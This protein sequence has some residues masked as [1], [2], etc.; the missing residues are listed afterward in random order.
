MGGDYGTSAIIGFLF[1][2]VATFFTIKFLI[3]QIRDVCS[4]DYASVYRKPNSFNLTRKSDRFMYRD[5]DV[6]RKK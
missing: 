2:V 6:I 5:R 3:G 1:G 4:D